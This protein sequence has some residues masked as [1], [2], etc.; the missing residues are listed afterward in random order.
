MLCQRTQSKLLGKCFKRSRT[1]GRRRGRAQVRQGALAGSLTC[2]TGVARTCPAV[3]AAPRQCA[4]VHCRPSRATGQAPDGCA[5]PAAPAPRAAPSGQPGMLPAGSQRAGTVA[6]WLAQAPALWQ[7]CV[8]SLAT[9]SCCAA[10]GAATRGHVS[11]PVDERTPAVSTEPAHC[12][13]TSAA[14]PACA[15]AAAGWQEAGGLARTQKRAVMAF[16]QIG[17]CWAPSP[18]S[19]EGWA[20]PASVSGALRTRP[21]SLSRMQPCAR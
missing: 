6:G 8:P 10:A 21:P 20:W 12:R 19:P 7:R 2:C 1:G 18:G 9:F 16:M 14:W 11:T 13:L 15:G 5:R 3:R 4:S 17:H